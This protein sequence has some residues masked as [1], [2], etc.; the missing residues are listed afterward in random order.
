MG[1]SEENV[2]LGRGREGN[3]DAPGKDSART[4][5]ETAPTI[6]QGC[7]R[8][9]LKSVPKAEVRASETSAAIG[10][11]TLR[12]LSNW[13]DTDRPASIDAR[14]AFRSGV[15]SSLDMTPENSRNWD[16]AR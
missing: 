2:R 8:R 16:R 15:S 3:G 11:I 4:P 6:S 13:S 7:D 10:S 14:T 9:Y 1:S 5:A 12:E